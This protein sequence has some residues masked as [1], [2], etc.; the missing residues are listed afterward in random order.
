MTYRFKIN[1]EAVWFVAVAAGT[2]ILQ[3]LATL[4]VDK[5]ADWRVWLVGLLAATIRAGAGAALS[6][7]TAPRQAQPTLADQILALSPEERAALGQEVAERGAHPPPP[8]PPA[9][10]DTY[11][12][13]GRG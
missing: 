13:L 6:L 4:D 8:P 1:Q 12:E 7:L 9:W 11:R 5:I 3:A 2:V 10:M